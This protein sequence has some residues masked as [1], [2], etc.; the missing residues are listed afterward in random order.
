MAKRIVSSQVLRAVYWSDMSDT[1][2][3]ESN[4]DS[5]RVLWDVR[6]RLVYSNKVRSQYRECDNLSCENSRVDPESGEKRRRRSVLRRR[7]DLRRVVRSWVED[8]E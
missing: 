8:D 6:P 2:V 1:N 5:L 7:L 3:V 4:R